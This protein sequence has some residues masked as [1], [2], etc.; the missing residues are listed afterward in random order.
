[1]AIKL[2]DR[3]RDT[4]TGFEGIVTS[5]AK[6]LHGC[7]SILIKPTELKDGIPIDSFWFDELRIKTIKEKITEVTPPGEGVG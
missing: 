6:N 1:M 2:G 4:I 5:I 3:A 7:N